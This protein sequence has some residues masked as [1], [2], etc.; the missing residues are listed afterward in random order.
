ML[1][2]HVGQSRGNRSKQRSRT[3]QLR[4]L[5]ERAGFLVSEGLTHFNSTL[6]GRHYLML[7]PATPKKKV[8]VATKSIRKWDT[9]KCVISDRNDAGYTHEDTSLTFRL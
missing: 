4:Q 7:F 2:L 3:W 6:S 5:K 8:I 1:L 9:Q